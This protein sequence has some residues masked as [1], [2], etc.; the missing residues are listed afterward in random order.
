MKRS[1]F[2]FV[3]VVSIAMSGNVLVAGNRIS[4]ETIAQQIREANIARYASKV[5]RLIEELGNRDILTRIRAADLLGKSCDA[6]GVEILGEHLIN[7]SNEE[8]RAQCA[9]SLG[10]IGSEKAIPFLIKALNDPNEKVN[11]T[12]A[13]SLSWLNEKQKCLPV[14]SRML[15]DDN[16]NVRM[17]ALE[18]LRNVGNLEAIFM[19][20]GVLDH[21]DPY[22]KVS[23]AISLAILG[24][25]ASVLPILQESLNNEDKDIRAAALRGLRYITPDDKIMFLVE[26]ALSDSDYE[27]RERVKFIMQDWGVSEDEINKKLPV[28]KKLATTVSY[29]VQSAINYAETWW[30]G[31]NTAKYHDYSYVG[32][33]CAH[34]VSQCLKAGG[35]DLSAGS[36]GSGNGVD[37]WGCIP[38]VLNLDANLHYY[39][40]T[41][42]QVR[43]G[44]PSWVLKGDP[45]LFYSNDGMYHHYCRKVM[46]VHTIITVE[47]MVCTIILLSVSLAIQAI[48]GTAMLTP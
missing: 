42:R 26:N 8:V 43:G 29:D 7:D 5:P 41:Q 6:Q 46:M 2:A 16:R 38:A 22:V 10:V 4:P 48:I 23:A 11:R 37:Y 40:N 28:A 33:D 32:G 3:V 45:I 9:K 21:V 20:K 39:Q 35:L 14:L 1:I 31:R 44:E 17:E 15:K 13:V 36:N 27:V 24:E 25:K 47:K 34:F 19:I 18:G 12:S 30:N